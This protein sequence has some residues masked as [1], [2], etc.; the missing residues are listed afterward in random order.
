MKQ[1][2]KYDGATTPDTQLR[3]SMT[4]GKVDASYLMIIRWVANI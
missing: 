1:R 4:L 2:T 3:K